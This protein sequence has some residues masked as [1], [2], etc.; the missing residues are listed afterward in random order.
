MKKLSLLLIL[1]A[2]PALA[3]SGPFFSL[4]NTDFVVLIAFL[5]FV[6]IVLWA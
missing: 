6:A 5:V 1:A 2:H 4:H 3:A